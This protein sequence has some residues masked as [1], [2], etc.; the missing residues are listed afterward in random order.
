MRLTKTEEKVLLQDILQLDSQGLLP[1]L[2]IIRDK[3]LAICKKSMTMKD[4][5]F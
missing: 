1:T 4:G 2:A 3:A 5:S